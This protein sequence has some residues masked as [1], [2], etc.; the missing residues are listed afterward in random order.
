VSRV[1]GSGPGDAELFERESDVA[2]IDAALAGTGGGGDGGVLLLEGEAGIGKTSLLG[3]LRRRAEARGTR[4]LRAHGSEMEGEFGFGV[5]RQLFDGVL[6]GLDPAARMRLFQGPA[7]L[8]AA[9]FGLGESGAIEVGPAE[10]TLYGLFWLV[11]ALAESGGPLVLAI[12]DAHWADTA[13]LRFLRYLSGR[14]EG[15]PVLLAV[16]VRPH[17][18]G[19]A[20]P[21]LAELGEVP[22]ATTLRPRSLSAASTA[23]LV[24]GRLGTEA[25]APIAI[26]CHE[27]TGGNPGLI[28][29]LLVELENRPDASTLSPQD[30]AGMGSERIA[31]S[32]AER[33]RQLDPSALEVVRAVAVLG[34]GSDLRAVAALAGVERGRAAA[35]LDGLAA[36]SVLVPGPGNGFVHPL[37]RGAV[38]E[39]IPPAARSEAHARAAAIL[40]EGAAEP[41]EIAAHLLLC[42]PGGFA[43]AVDILDAAAARA[44]ARGAPE[45][46]VAYLRQALA[47]GVEPARRGE[48]LHRLG[49]AELALRDPASLEHLGQAAELATDPAQGLAISLELV[50]VLSIAGQ[51]EAAVA[52]ID[53][54]FARY[55]AE[56]LPALLDLEAARGAS[57]AYDPARNA[58]FIADLPRLLDLVR[59]R[60]DDASSALRWLLAA[61]GALGQMPREQVLE[62]IG[63]RGQN[64]GLV[65]D[66]RE[67][68]QV[69]QALSAL[70]IVEA[71][72]EA[73]WGAAV[74]AE[75]G[76]R[77]GS[78]IAMVC[79]LGYTAA[80]E[81]RRGRLAESEASLTAVL[82]LLGDNDLGLM[83]LTTVFQFTPDTLLERTALEPAVEMVLEL[84]LPPTFDA[85]VNG[86]FVRDVRAALRLGR[87]E[88]AAAVTALR[89]AEPTMRGVGWGPRIS[90]WRSRLALALPAAEQ[91]EAELLVA[92]ELDLA[93]AIE[94]ARAIGVA[95]RAGALLG[96]RGETIARLE[97]SA[98]VLRAG[99]LPLELARSLT[100]LG[101]A[102]A[103]A[104]RRAEARE[105]LREAADLARRCGAER[106]AERTR[107]ELRVAGAKPR[108]QALSGPD[109]LTPS[110]R[111]VATAAATGLTNREIGQALFVSMSTVEMHLTNT[112]RK[113]GVSSRAEL[114]VAIEADAAAA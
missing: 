112:Y 73:E 52:T 107:E 51:W 94:S 9:I 55:G 30:V 78:L 106:L 36:V 24:A 105:R 57:R 29:E 5:V 101:A 70:V 88:R 21:T 42:E 49:S 41:E 95:L 84:E 111:R 103:R 69:G 80:I 97:E 7:T 45:S 62:L 20:A 109:S 43:G 26:A 12:D 15:L 86:A 4:V 10:T 37:L 14:L 1:L 66:G 44:T 8:A 108:R 28:A 19:A 113:L 100:E 85:T 114:A 77:L 33:A 76:R 11:I 92:E 18:P 81:Q 65:R 16:A 35:I 6:R 47:E 74:A 31:A 60:D 53:G 54:A 58:E 93:R 72:E 27:A 61:V 68:S 104:N 22:N 32:I 99:S 63:P 98:S 34:S 102:L 40:A 83:A 38:Y 96:P 82:E 110:E 64:W 23:S 89:E 56:D 39:A 59:G 3:E 87:G 25:A 75:D 17:E 90:P 50:D 67:S 71:L 2:R 46:A 79:S 48:L 13:S 91:A